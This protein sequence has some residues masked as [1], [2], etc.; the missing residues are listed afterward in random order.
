M[1]EQL[2]RG[3]TTIRDICFSPDKASTNFFGILI[4]INLIN[5][6][7]GKAAAETMASEKTV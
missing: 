4:T 3:S 6:I 2:Q 5:N 7:T 1:M